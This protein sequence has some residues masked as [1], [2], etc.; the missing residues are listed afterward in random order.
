MEELG[1]GLKELKGIGTPQ[2][3]NSINS[4]GPL[5]LSRD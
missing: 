3:E 4:P 1:D 5:R 2:E